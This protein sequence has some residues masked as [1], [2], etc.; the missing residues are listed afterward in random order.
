M[1]RYRQEFLQILT[2]LPRVLNSA[3]ANHAAAAVQEIRSKLF[4]VKL[5]PGE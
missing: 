1:S 5:F 2:S 3:F 4:V